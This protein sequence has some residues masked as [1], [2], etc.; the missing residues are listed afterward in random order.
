MAIVA[1][2]N[3]TSVGLKDPFW[4]DETP[5]AVGLNRTSVGL[6]GLT[7]M[8][9]VAGSRRPQSNQ[10]GIERRQEAELF[11]L[12]ENASIEPAWD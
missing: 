2:L 11:G 8:D 6:K 10:R 7:R 9:T 5:I 12:Y 4:Y 1:G 3:R